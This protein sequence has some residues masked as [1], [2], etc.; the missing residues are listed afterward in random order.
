MVEAVNRAIDERDFYVSEWESDFL[1][2]VQRALD[3]GRGLSPKQDDC[4][5]KIWLRAEDRDK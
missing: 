1:E 2:S 3:A 5:L 4:L